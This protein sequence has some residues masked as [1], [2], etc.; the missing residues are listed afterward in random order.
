M[1]SPASKHLASVRANT[2]YGGLRCFI[3]TL[4]LV[5]FSL[6][7]VIAIWSVVDQE[8]NKA[9]GWALGSLIFPAIRALAFIPLDIADA[10]LHRKAN[11]KSP[12]Q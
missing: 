4:A 9:V 3:T 8:W 5:G 2:A 10:L 11:P 7:A 12:S 6:A 1:F